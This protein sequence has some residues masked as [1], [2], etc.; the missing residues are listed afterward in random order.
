MAT[1]LHYSATMVNK[2]VQYYQEYENHKDIV[3]FIKFFSV[4]TWQRIGFVRSQDNLKMHETTITQNLLFQFRI[5][6]SLY[7]QTIKM[8]EA[9]NEKVNGNDI[10]I[11]IWTGRNYVAFPCQAK[12]SYKNSK[13]QWNQ[14]ER[15]KAID[16]LVGKKKGA[17]KQ[18]IDSLIAYA[19]SKR[20][21]PIYLFYNFCLHRPTIN[22]IIKA[23][24]NDIELYGC[25][26]ANAEQIK[27]TYVTGIQWDCIPS[28]ADIHPS[29]AAPFYQLFELINNAPLLPSA[30]RSVLAGEGN[31][32]EVLSRLRRYNLDELAANDYWVPVTETAE[33]PV[34]RSQD[35][36]R[37]NDEQAN[38]FNPAFRIIF[39]GG[40]F[41]G[42]PGQMI[43]ML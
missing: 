25:S 23:T 13:R 29:M 36:V 31:L 21:L 42:F 32:E 19:K 41:S 26:F 12:V 28:F 27:D 9:K 6:A 24:S 35:R 33:L 39:T 2:L 18:Q 10:E 22:G 3:S 11:Y 37:T 15:Y 5:L 43:S 14:P 17:G 38:E 40:T 8:F 1:N 20:G 34:R 16:H 4:S 30:G 7:P